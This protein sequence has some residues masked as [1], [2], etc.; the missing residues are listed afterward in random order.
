MRH[1]VLAHFTRARTKPG[2]ENTNQHTLAGSSDHAGAVIYDVSAV[3]PSPFS[4]R[5]HGPGLR[6]PN[7][8]ADLPG[9]QCTGSDLFSLH[10]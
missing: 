4:N 2:A 10:L 7:R 1:L 5:A 6:K 9:A 3:G 8:R